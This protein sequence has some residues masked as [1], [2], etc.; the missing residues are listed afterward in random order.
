MR[1]EKWKGVRKFKQIRRSNSI[2]ISPNQTEY[3]NGYHILQKTN[4]N[5][6]PFLPDQFCQSTNETIEQGKTCL[7][8]TKRGTE[9]TSKKLNVMAKYVETGEVAFLDRE[10]R[11]D[12]FSEVIECP[13]P[14]IRSDFLNQIRN[15]SLLELCEENCVGEFHLIEDCEEEHCLIA[16]QV[17]R[18]MSD[19]VQ[20]C[21]EIDPRLK[22]KLFWTGSSAEGTKMWLPD[23]FD[24]LMEIVGLRGKCMLDG[25]SSFQPL[26]KNECQRLWSDFCLHDDSLI[27]SST[28][29]KDYISIL[30]WKAASLL[31]RKNYQNIRFRLCRYDKNLNTFIKTTKVGVNITVCWC[32]AKYKNLIIAIDLTPAISIDLTEKELQSFHEHSVGRLLESFIHILPYVDHGSK[33]RWRASFSLTEVHIIKNLSQKQR[34]LYKGMKF[35]RDIHKTDFAEIPSYHLKIFLFN[36]LLED[37]GYHKILTDR[38]LNFNSSLCHILY[39]L[40]FATDRDIQHFFL[41]YYVNLFDYDIRWIKSTLNILE[42]C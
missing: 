27:L 33:E 12:C 1:E 13:F 17:F 36:L 15:S 40:D 35:F 2:P 41:K 5:F 7:T 21:S 34:A 23:E 28:K 31:D 25:Q 16:K 30:L 26:L 10:E 19:L 4:Q 29:L 14:T 6:L 42:Q 39:R 24:F 20:K 38:I 22:S 37:S 8:S 3:V 11:K 18:L 9:W 32:G